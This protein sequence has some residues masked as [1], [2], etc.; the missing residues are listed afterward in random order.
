MSG[1]HELSLCQSIISIVERA[2][3]GRTVETVH[4]QVG[5][6]R[7]VIPGTLEYYWRLITEDGPLAGSELAI[8]HV[9]VR[10]R[11]HACDAATPAPDRL[12]LVCGV[13]DSGQVM[14][15]AGEEFMVTMIDVR[16]ESELIHG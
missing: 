9:P 1:V 3:E 16:D 12:M 11:C 10:V 5:L 6:R 15:I 14:V 2:C 13:C 8:E 4:L 7:Q